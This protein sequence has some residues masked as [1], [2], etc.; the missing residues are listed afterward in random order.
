MTVLHLDSHGI[1]LT[2]TKS[3]KINLLLN[4][5]SYWSLCSLIMNSRV[6]TQETLLLLLADQ[7]FRNF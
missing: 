2:S 6:N 1:S 3:F 7:D 5:A 4:V